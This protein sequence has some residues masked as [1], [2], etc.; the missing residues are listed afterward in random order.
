MSEIPFM[1]TESG[2][3]PGRFGDP[4]VIAKTGRHKAKTLILTA[5]RRS[6]YGKKTRMD[7]R[8]LNVKD[9]RLNVSL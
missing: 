7:T 4:K 3:R 6:Y 2:P 8:T 5:E 9:I 1:A